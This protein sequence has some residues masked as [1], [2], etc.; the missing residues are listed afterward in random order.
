LKYDKLTHFGAYAGLSVL[1]MLAFERWRGVFVALSMILLGALIEA[2][3]YF[4]PGRTPDLIDALA[5]TLGVL[6]GL[7]LRFAAAFSL[8][9]YS[10]I[11]RTAVFAV[12]FLQIT[13]GAPAALYAQALNPCDLN[14]DHVV[15]IVDVQLI[16]TMTGGLLPCTANIAGPGICTPAVYDA[17]KKA[18]LTGECAP[19][20]VSLNWTASV[21]PSVKGYNVYRGTRAGGPYTKLTAAPVSQTSFVDITVLAGQTYYY[22]A[23]AVDANKNESAY[24]KQALAVIPNP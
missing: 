23:T 18:A 1:S 2:A 22:V 17:V 4:S 3:Q 13:V 20:S 9:R 7:A 5:N 8:A 21:S 12:V 16:A 24:S 15:N 10:R 6:S 14:G 19:H 11:C